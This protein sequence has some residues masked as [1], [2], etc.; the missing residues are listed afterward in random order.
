[1]CIGQD[2]WALNITEFPPYILANMMYTTT[3]ESIVTAPKIPDLISRVEEFLER[4]FTVI[5]NVLSREQ[6]E[7]GRQ[8]LTDL[9]ER[10]SDIATKRGWKN[11]TY[12]CSYMLPGKHE[13]FRFVPTNPITLSFVRAILGQDCYLSSLN[14]LTMA[15]GGPDQ[16]LH[17]DQAEHTPG[18]V[19]NINVTHPLD[20]FTKEN[21]ATRI[22]PMSQH[23][24]GRNRNFTDEE[25]NAVQVEAPAGSVI[26]FNGGAIHAGSANRTR[27]LRRCLHAF[28]TRAWVRPQWDYTRSFTPEVIATLSDEQRRLFGFIRSEQVYDLATDEVSH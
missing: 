22:V 24:S 27:N 15:P 2:D 20:D 5:P 4:G 9:F 8:L 7:T 28:Y 1:M 23:R 19:I 11:A 16:T 14:G 26:A 21:G 13:F 10:E 6:V 25:Q 12:Q 18:I 3:S 17:L